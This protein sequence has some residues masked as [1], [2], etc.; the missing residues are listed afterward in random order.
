MP[1]VAADRRRPD[2]RGFAGR[3]TR[4]RARCCW[5]APAPPPPTSRRAAR[6]RRSR[7]SGPLSIVVVKPRGP[8]YTRATRPR[9]ARGAA[10]MSRTAPSASPRPRRSLPRLARIADHGQSE[11]GAAAQQRAVGGHRGEAATGAHRRHRL[12]GV[13]DDPQAVREVRF[14]PQAAHDG[15]RGDGAEQRVLAHLEGR[16]VAS[17]GF[18]GARDLA[19]LRAVDPDHGDVLHRNEGAGAKPQ[20]ERREHREQHGEAQDH[21][22]SAAGER[23][24]R[25]QCSPCGGRTLP[26]WRPRRRS[27]GG[28]ARSLASARMHAVPLSEL[29]TLRLGGPAARLVAIDSEDALV[30]AVRAADAEGAPLLAAGGRQQRGRGRCGLR[31]HRRAGATRGVEGI[32]MADGRIRLDV[33]AGENWDALV[34]AC[35]ADGLAGHRGAVRDPRQRRR[36]ADPE[37][38]RLRPGGRRRHRRGARTGPRQRRTARP[39]AR[40]VPVRLPHERLQ[41]RPRPLGR[42]RRELRA[43]ADGRVGA[44]PLRGAGRS[45]RRRDRRAGAGR[46]RARG[47]ARPAPRQGHGARPRRPRHGQRRLVLHEPDPSRAGLRRLRAARGGAPRGRRRA[48]RAGPSSRAR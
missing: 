9:S 13:D 47:G 27:P 42:P 35:V 14:G 11:G 3:G 38:R 34:A 10:A 12:V 28:S 2:A 17:G 46:R 31:R 41:A 25:S 48:R 40:G 20:R 26:R 39:G 22:R 32:R 1:F 5:R 29:T 8:R 4:P 18:E 19:R 21:A 44:D 30:D 23:G 24:H 16:H 37:R 45:P 36:D 43:R 15:I 6:P 7:A 33:A